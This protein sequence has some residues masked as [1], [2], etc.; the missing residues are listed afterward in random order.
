MFSVFFN[1]FFIFIFLFFLDLTS[2]IV[3]FSRLEKIEIG[4]TKG[5]TLTT[6]VQQTYN[7]FQNAV[8]SI[9]NVKYDIM[10]V[11]AK[12][13]DDDF[14]EFR[15]KIKELERRL[16][17]VLTQG[18][19]DSITIQG[20]FKL[21]DSFET[22]LDRPII[23]DELER[24]HNTLIESFSIDLKF[25]QE[26]FLNNK[27]DPPININQPPMSGA[28]IWCSGLKERIIGPMKKLNELAGTSPSLLE[29]E[30]AKEMIKMYNS[31]IESLNNYVRK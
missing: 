5:K 26:I 24:K 29:R 6:T 31:I 11:N 1:F 22:L 28:I 16:G 3:Q 4:G 27:D 17:S 25:T 15:C 19:D 9:Q 13:F 20:R 7:D 18:F 23:Q 8:L 30:E 14:Y 12:Q 2:T 10:N 21:L